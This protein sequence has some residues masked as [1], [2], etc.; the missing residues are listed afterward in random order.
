MREPGEEVSREALEQYEQRSRGQAF[1]LGPEHRFTESHLYVCV[2]VCMCVS[3]KLT[4]G[5][6]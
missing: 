3:A 1:S 4:A 2:C 6:L 5:N